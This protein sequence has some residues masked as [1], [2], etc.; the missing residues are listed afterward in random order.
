MFLPCRYVL[1]RATSSKAIRNRILLVQASKSALQ[2]DMLAKTTSM[3][4]LVRQPVDFVLWLIGYVHHEPAPLLLMDCER[5]FR[6]VSYPFHVH[7]PTI[8]YSRGSA[9]W[10]LVVG[11]HLR[12]IDAPSRDGSGASSSEPQAAS[13]Q[14]QP[15][16]LHFDSVAGAHSTVDVANRIRGYVFVSTLC[17][18]CSLV[19]GLCTLRTSVRAC[20]VMC[21]FLQH[22]GE[23]DKSLV[24]RRWH[25][26]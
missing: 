13:H 11:C 6:R 22:C 5:S 17:S 21:D 8:C 18:L 20:A 19:H 26:Q 12:H 24:L 1:Y 15:C 23:V 10:S 3:K 7:R 14:W 25:C 9:H 16:L 4:Q 2:D